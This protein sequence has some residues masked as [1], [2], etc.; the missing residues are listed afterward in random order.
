MTDNLL[1]IMPDR[2]Y[3]KSERSVGVSA[4]RGLMGNVSM[5]SSKIKNI[6]DICH[7]S[8]KQLGY[9]IFNHPASQEEIKF[10]EQENEVCLPDDFKDMLRNANGVTI[11]SHLVQIFPLKQIKTYE[12]FNN[13]IPDDFIVIGKVI[14]DGEELC[15]SKHT[16]KYIINDHGDYQEYDNFP[17]VLDWIIKMLG[18]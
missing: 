3:D 8:D 7:K 9:C 2:N 5:V 13:D 18:Y 1:L 12:C 17:D 16:G 10:W 4:R 11:D 6:K 15:L 14:G